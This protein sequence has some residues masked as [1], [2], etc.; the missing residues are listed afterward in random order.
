[1]DKSDQAPIKFITDNLDAF[2]QCYD[3]LSD[4]LSVCLFVCVLLECTMFAW[5][6][7]CNV[8]EVTVQSHL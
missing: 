7:T 8:W 4:I 2:L 3:T 5:V 6:G 1:M